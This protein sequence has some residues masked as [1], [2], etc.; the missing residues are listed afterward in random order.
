M[1]YPNK[2]NKNKEMGKKVVWHWSLKTASTIMEIRTMPFK[3]SGTN[4]ALASKTS[5]TNVSLKSDE[6]GKFGGNGE[7]DRNVE[8][9][10]KNVVASY[11]AGVCVT[12]T[13]WSSWSLDLN[14]KGSAFILGTIL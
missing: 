12:A 1:A 5:S 13:V 3:T 8:L 2:L 11:D 6:F 9:T 10:P 14:I 7:D 4:E